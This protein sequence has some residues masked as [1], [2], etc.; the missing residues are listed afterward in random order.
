MPRHQNCT[1]SVPH[2]HFCLVRW[3]QGLKQ[4][5]LHITGFESNFFFTWEKP[6]FTNITG[7]KHINP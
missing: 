2:Q 1:I 5:N 4:N 6:E 7:G 3:S